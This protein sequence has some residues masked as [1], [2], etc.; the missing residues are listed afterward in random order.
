MG[1]RCFVDGQRVKIA[2]TAIADYDP[3]E[4]LLSH[5]TIMA[6][7]ET[8]Q[9]DDQNVDFTD[10]FIQADYEPFINDNYD[11]WTTKVLLNSYKTF[12]GAENYVEHVQVKEN[13]RG[14]IIDCVP[15]W[16][17]V[18]TADGSE[19]RVLY[20]D[21]LVAT[22]R[23]HVSLVEDI[24]AGRMNT[25][26]MGCFTAGTP[27]VMADGT[28]KA[29]D[30]IYPGELIR[31]HTGEIKPVK[32]VQIRYKKEDI[33]ELDITGF[34]KY[35]KQSATYDHVRVTKE[36]PWLVRRPREYCACGCGQKVTPGRRFIKGHSYRVANPAVV[37]QEQ[38][39]ILQEID[40]HTVSWVE[41]KDLKVGDQVLIPRIKDESNTD[42]SIDQ[43]WLLGLFLAEGYFG[44]KKSITYWSINK[45]EFRTIGR[46][47][48]NILRKEF[49][50]ETKKYIG[51]SGKEI[52]PIRVK[53]AKD[54]N[55]LDIR[56]CS[57]ALVGWF[58][59]LCGKGSFEKKLHESLL[60]LPEDQTKALIAGWFDGDGLKQGCVTRSKDLA[61]QMLLLAN[62]VGY[63]AR[64]R[65]V[66]LEQKNKKGQ[67]KV[68]YHIDINNGAD[69]ADYA[70]TN[71]FDSLL[72]IKNIFTR[73]D[74][75]YCWYPIKGIKKIPYD[76]KVWNLEVE[77]DHSYLVNGFAVHNCNVAF[78]ICTACGDIITDDHE[79]EH[80][81]N[82]KGAHFFDKAGN[83]RVIAELCGHETKP[84]SVGF[85]EASWVIIPAFRG[86]KSR[87]II[88][89]ESFDQ[90]SEGEWMNMRSELSWDDAK[91]IASL[92][93]LAHHISDRR[94]EAG[95]F[96][97]KAASILGSKGVIDPFKRTVTIKVANPFVVNKPE[98]TPE[99]TEKLANP[100]MKEARWR[101]DQYLKDEII[102]DPGVK[103]N[104]YQESMEKLTDDSGPDNPSIF[105][106][107]NKILRTNP[108]QSSST[109]QD[110]ELG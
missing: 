69:I 25:M 84:N 40:T 89:L 24:L 23:S 67:N 85:T 50:E 78:S 14:K 76:G 6:G 88:N 13:S 51:R 87:G 96:I 82:F 97:Q 1:D 43:A 92:L 45:K 47:L 80:I 110:I 102:E 57:P 38:T 109:K 55:G 35:K 33:Y 39:T 90:M 52:D 75:D 46:R 36:H 49:P 104:L 22:H 54:N 53:R 71:K 94:D 98:P 72:N 99:P 48:I 5:V 42:I 58:Y 17:M 30:E 73:C 59:K 21:I 31:T 79:C 106:I 93:K 27:V 108:S 15:R 95:C 12:M 86:A 7:V 68:S 103:D 20:L 11:A 29:I 83:K 26:S 2:T 101:H 19:I 44:Y 62:K 74:E 91:K 77:E 37:G 28:R 105:E 107:K 41:T 81:K 16:I 61:H 65:E 32:N 70:A 4:Y 60:R 9:G 64:L 18:Q 34:K 100:F 63:R 56:V 3:K 10:Y 66:D 8:E